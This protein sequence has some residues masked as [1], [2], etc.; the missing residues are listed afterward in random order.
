MIASF[1]CEETRDIWQGSTSKKL[2]QHIQRAAK[3]KLKLLHAAVTIDDLRT[4]PSNHLEKL[5]GDRAGQYSIRINSQ[6]RLC[7]SWND[8]IASFV[9]IID[10][11]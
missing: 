6:W 3:R 9:E 2:P 1:A 8:G 10:Y 4:P 7:F 5:R 11:H